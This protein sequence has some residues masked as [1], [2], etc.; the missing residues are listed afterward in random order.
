MNPAPGAE[1][2][3]IL[4]PFN[5]HIHRFPK[6]YWRFTDDCMR[7]LMKEFPW[8]IVERH[9]YAAMPSEV[10]GIGFNRDRFPDFDQRCSK[11]KEL[12]L[13]NAHEPSTLTYRLRM[14]LGAGLFRRKYFQSFRSRNDLVLDL[15]RPGD[16]KPEAANHVP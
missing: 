7:E 2:L 4:C 10:F 1:I 12:L 9:G 3:A 16:P 13:A 6:D 5:L 8:L 11:F 15:V 14:W